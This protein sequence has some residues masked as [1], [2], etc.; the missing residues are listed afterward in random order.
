MRKRNNY[1]NSYKKL[2]NKINK[3][4]IEPLIGIYQE[5]TKEEM[6][7]HEGHDG[8]VHWMGRTFAHAPLVGAL[9]S[10]SS[11]QNEIMSARA[12]AVLMLKGKISTG[13]YS[14]NKILGMAYL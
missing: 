8:K 11:L 14:F 6:A 12:K 2:A 3:E 5:L 13:Q 9:A 1:I 4:D 7:E 10:L